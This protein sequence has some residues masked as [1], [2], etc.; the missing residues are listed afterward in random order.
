MNNLITTFT[1]SI[2][3]FTVTNI[4]D[5]IILLLFFSQIDQNFRRRHIFIGQYLGFAV[6]ILLSL[7]GF[8]GGLFIKRELIGLLLPV[9]SFFLEFEKLPEK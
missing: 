7:P 8:F 4:D 9:R 5:I 2:I 6:I 1:Q 3:A